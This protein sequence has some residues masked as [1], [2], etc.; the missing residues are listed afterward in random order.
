ML[1][2]A[3]PAHLLE[4]NEAHAK[5]VWSPTARPLVHTARAQAYQT[6]PVTKR[7]PINTYRERVLARVPQFRPRRNDLD[8]FDLPTAS[9]SSR[10]PRMLERDFAMLGVST[11]LMNEAHADVPYPNSPP[12]SPESLRA[13]TLLS[14][15]EAIRNAGAF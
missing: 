13:A 4:K 3:I 14:H 15:F 12:N 10:L 1:Y 9:L 6:P 5:L 8:D 7:V 11:Q 2:A